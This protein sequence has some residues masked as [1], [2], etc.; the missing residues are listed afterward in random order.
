MERWMTDLEKAKTRAAEQ[1]KDLFIIYKGSS[2]HPEQYGVPERMF[3]CGTVRKHLEERVVL[4][5]QDYPPGSLKGRTLFSFKLQ[6]KTS[7]PELSSLVFGL[8]GQERNE[9]ASLQTITEW[10]PTLRE[11]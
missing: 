5:M 9:N 10:L 6:V 11:L 3:T 7:L 8:N 1:K 2:W 4:L